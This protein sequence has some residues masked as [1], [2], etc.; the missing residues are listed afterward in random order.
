MS[1]G[2]QD[3]KNASEDG[4]D[5]IKPYFSSIGFLILLTAY[6]L[7][8]GEY[9]IVS[10]IVVA[11]AWL[12]PAYQGKRKQDDLLQ[13]RSEK[14]AAA[15]SE[16]QNITIG[17]NSDLQE[18]FQHFQTELDQVRT[19]IVDAAETLMSS[20]NGLE[21]NTRREEEI[22]RDMILRVAQSSMDNDGN[23]TATNEAVESSE[24]DR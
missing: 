17:I 18:Q 10:L 9:I 4:Y 12:Y 1:K 5:W 2:H 19:M 14:D 24:Y 21:N 16:V 22:L 6:S 23:S 3:N 8:L 20:F 7:W 13:V 11:A 15:I